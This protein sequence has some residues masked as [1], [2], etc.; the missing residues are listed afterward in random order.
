MRL[1]SRLALAALA[2]ALVLAVA[3][4][5]QAAPVR[6]SGTTPA[7]SAQQD[8]GLCRQDRRFLVGAHQSNLAEILGGYVAL[9][10]SQRADVRDIARTLIEHHTRLDADVRAAAR[11]YGVP[12]PPTPTARQVREL[13]SVAT[14]PGDTFDEAWLRLQETSHVRTLALIDAE[15][16][17]GCAPAVQ[18]LASTARPVV[19][20]HLHMVRMALERT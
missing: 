3:T 17:R 10:R 15:L 11:R 7:A 5:V 19:E 2:G 4:P 1:T 12:L 8:D 18:A 16:E 20:E 9:L 13:L 14:R 6:T